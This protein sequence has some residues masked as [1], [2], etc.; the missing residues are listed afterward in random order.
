MKFSLVVEVLVLLGIVVDP[1]TAGLKDSIQAQGYESPKTIE[2]Q[3][4][5]IRTVDEQKQEDTQEC[6]LEKTE[7]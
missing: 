4:D 1:T 6:K 2:Q 7:K 3:L 5:D